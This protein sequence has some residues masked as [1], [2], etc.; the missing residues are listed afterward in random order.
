MLKKF[1]LILIFTG[2]LSF[3]GV[4]LGKVLAPH[5]P[6]GFTL[7]P[8]FTPPSPGV[9]EVIHPFPPVN[10]TAFE[11]FSFKTFLGRPLGSLYGFALVRFALTSVWFVIAVYFLLRYLRGFYGPRAVPLSW[12]LIVA[13]LIVTNVAEIGENFTFHEWP[14]MG[15]LEHNFLLILPHLWGAFLVALGTWF[16][17]REVK[18]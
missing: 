17:L 2:V 1:L 4:Y 12:L 3:G 11:Y 13:G 5:L 6:P 18:G 10:F 7:P 8:Q 15:I 9:G 14:Y 16:L